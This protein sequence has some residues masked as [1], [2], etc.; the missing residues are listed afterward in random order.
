MGP[1]TRVVLRT[2]HD[3]TDFESTRAIMIETTG[4]VAF[5]PEGQTTS[6][7]VAGL[8]GG[9]WHPLRVTRILDTGTTATTVYCGY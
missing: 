2:P 9:I 4:P 5:I 3:T 6:V 1:L 7:V 8:S